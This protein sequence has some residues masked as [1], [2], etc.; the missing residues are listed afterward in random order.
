MSGRQVWSKLQR[1]KTSWGPWVDWSFIWRAMPFIPITIKCLRFFLERG[2]TLSIQ[3]QVTPRSPGLGLQ[4]REWTVCVAAQADGLLSW[5]P[6][7]YAAAF[8]HLLTLDASLSY[9]STSPSGREALLAY[10]Y[11]Q[12]PFVQELNSHI[13]AAAVPRSL[14]NVS[15]TVAVEPVATGGKLVMSS[16]PVLQKGQPVQKQPVPFSFEVPPPCR[17]H[18][19]Q[20]M[21]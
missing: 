4:L 9:H 8:L 10:K 18:C 5:L 20:D 14:D 7:S 21:M 16:F 3:K 6:R 2:V 12:K 1:S 17:R 15:Q 19:H 11:V 13:D